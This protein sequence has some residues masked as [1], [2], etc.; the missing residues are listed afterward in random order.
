MIAKLQALPDGD[1]TKAL[2]AAEQ[3]VA[4]ISKSDD[5]ETAAAALVVRATV[6][7]DPKKQED[8]LNEALKLKPAD[9]EALRV[10]AVLLMTE[11]KFDQALADLDALIKTDGGNPRL[12]EVRGMVLYQLKR[13]DDGNKSFDKAI[14]LQPGEVGP[15][16]QRARLRSQQKDTKGALDDLKAALNI[17]PDSAVVLLARARVYQ[18]SGDAKSAKADV[19]TALKNHPELP[20]LID[21][22]ALE[23]SISA[24]AGDYDEA[25][26]DLEEL[27]K[28]MPK[29]G[30]L[31]Y[32]IGML[33]SIS[34]QSA[35]AIEKY[36]EALANSEKKEFNIYRNRGDAYLNLGK[37]SEAIKDYEEA[38]KLKPEDPGLLNNFAWVLC[39]S[40]DDKLR[41]GK[42]AV[43][44]ATKASAA[45]DDKAPHILS[46][47]A[48]AY[49]ETGDFESAVKWSSKA[50]ELAGA[51]SDP[52]VADPDAIKEQL[53]KELD[54]YKN[55]KPVRELLTEDDEV[56]ARQKKKA[57]EKK[58]DEK[59][60]DEKK[61]DEKK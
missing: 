2:K 50:V 36:T 45:T 24:G 57:D 10:R 40:P 22:R 3:A 19:E 33:Y 42:R 21:A 12:Y 17:E 47:L 16:I 13:T 6:L 18:Q 23:A 39:T 9:E 8:D 49:A 5:P 30:E 48:A 37:H 51:V 55:K 28:I 46:T 26:S 56:K 29:N 35:K 7:E 61:P 27:L 43:E 31:L 25:I 53:Q 34:K 4:L 58:A 14:Q 60:S 59:K 11:K 32:Q 38:F 15:Y 1:K 54:S 52:E 44:M 20:D 41:D